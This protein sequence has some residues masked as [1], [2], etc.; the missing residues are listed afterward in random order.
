MYRGLTE[1]TL[2]MTPY[3]DEWGS[4]ISAYA[5]IK[6]SRGEKVGAMGVDFKAEEVYAVQRKAATNA[7]LGG[8]LAYALVFVA[9]WFAADRLTRPI[10]RLAGA[11]AAVERGEPFA[12]SD[13]ADVTAGGDEVAHLGR[14]F[15]D[16][17][18]TLRQRCAGVEAQ[19]RERTAELLAANAQLKQEIARRRQ[20]EEALR[21]SEGRFRT[22]FEDSPASLW[23]N[24][25]SGV[26]KYIDGLRD[27][28]VKDFRAYFESH[29]EDVARC[30]ALARVG[31]INKA[32]LAMHGAKSKDEFIEN[33]STVFGAEER[34]MFREELVAIAEG[35]TSFEIETVNRSLAGDKIYAVLRWSVPPGYEETYEKLLVSMLDITERRRLE[36]QVRESLSRRTRQVQT[37]ADVAQEVAGVPAPAELFRRVVGLVKERFGY[38]HVQVFLSDPAT[39]DLLLAEGYGEAGRAMKEAGHRIKFGKGVVG[40]AASSKQPVLVSDVSQPSAWLPNPHLPAT[41][42]E[43][44]APIVLRDKVLGVLDVQSD[45]AGRLSEEDEL[46]LSDLGGQ[47]AIAIES[48]RLLEEVRAARDRLQAL[49][50][51][52]VEVQEGERSHIARE[53]H[54]EVG[55]GLAALSAGLGQLERS[56]AGEPAIREQIAGLQRAVDAVWQNLRDMA[57][58]L[59]PAIILERFGPAA[60]LRQCVENFGSRHDLDVQFEV[61][62]LG[63]ERLPRDIEMAL[64]RVVQESLTNVV[65]HARATHAGVLLERRGDRLVVAVEDNG[66]GFDVQARRGG[67]G[68]WG[69]QD[70]A[71]ALGGALTVES[72]AGMG[73]V[74]TM[75]IPCAN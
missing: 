41:K 46:L 14:V 72:A 39:G 34:G 5:P 6:N 7:A 63:S 40:T 62:S 16:M 20:V 57:T 22:L 64:Y 38:Y 61:V 10:R 54:D 24:D 52:L 49:S 19:V 73:T 70:R 75:E 53:L 37:A 21:E 29:P 60:A 65:R 9:V 69:M 27:A 15:G 36:Q 67:L 43:L 35:K 32:T 23:V 13:V 28:G 45:V 47:L 18:M 31:E 33:L 66:V 71:E 48:A 12:L 55:Q 3:E 1:L 17:V 30:A 50:R 44:A 11:A 51:R 59:H 25:F 68:L 56:A 2:K 42:G 58:S 8:L 26:K 4:W 74:V